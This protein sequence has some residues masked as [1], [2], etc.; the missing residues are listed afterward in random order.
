MRVDFIRVIRVIRG[1]D[2]MAQTWHIAALYRFAHLPRYAALAKRLRLAGPRLGIQGTLLLAEEGINGTIAAPSREQLAEYLLIIRREKPLRR[3]EIK[4]AQCD[5]CPF[6]RFKIKLKPEIVTFR[7]PGIDPLTQAGAYVEPEDWNALI[8]D[9][10]VL[11]IDTRNHY[12]VEVGKFKGAVDPGTE[13]F[14]GFADFVK[15]Q[16]E[17]NQQRKV[18]MYCTGGIRCEKASAFLRQKGIDE[19]Y[20][21]HGG[22]LKY[23]ESVP[24]SHSRWEGECFVFDYRVAVDH[25]LQPTKKWYI[26][27]KSYLPARKSQANT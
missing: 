1:S 27:D 24:A 26:D 18:A 2:I 3:L 8:D 12:E 13:D 15:Q 5:F 9:P 20:H 19:V 21:L 7:Q 22:I 6:K 17:A 4:L 16:L 10:D 23:L 14:V 25:Q 11:L